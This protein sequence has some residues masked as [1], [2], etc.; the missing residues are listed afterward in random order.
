[1]AFSP[2]AGHTREF[3]FY[4]TRIRWH[5]LEH[6][7]AGMADVSI[8]DALITTVDLYSPQTIARPVFTHT[9]PEPGWHTIRIQVTGLQ[10]PASGAAIVATDG[11][12]V[13]F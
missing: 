7:L 8:D 5:A 4:G 3:G 12:E 10:A 9:F 1:M 11:F 2:V 6:A 13:T